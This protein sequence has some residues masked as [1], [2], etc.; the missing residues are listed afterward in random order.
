MR[1][2][3]AQDCSTNANELNNSVGCR[4]ITTPQLH[5]S[6]STIIPIH[7]I[8]TIILLARNIL[9]TV[10]EN[11]LFNCNSYSNFNRITPTSSM[12]DGGSTSFYLCMLEET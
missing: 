8:Y 6:P 7:G 12:W 10:R 9:D 1:D 3:T 5:H 2:N 11:S 4:S